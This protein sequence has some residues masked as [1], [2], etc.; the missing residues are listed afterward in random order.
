MATGTKK[1]RIGLSFQLTLLVSITNID[2]LNHTCV[3]SLRLHH[4]LDES[5]CPRNLDSGNTPP[6][7]R[8]HFTSMKPWYAKP[9]SALERHTTRLH[10][11]ISFLTA[12]ALLQRRVLESNVISAAIAGFEFEVDM[13]HMNGH[14]PATCY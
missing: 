12:S 13:D 6:T 10:S 9:Q 1:Y 2:L 3:S 7:I 11:S 5:P 4:A 14:S 8:S